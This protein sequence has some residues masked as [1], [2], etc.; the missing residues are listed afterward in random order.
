MHDLVVIPA[1][2]HAAEAAQVLLRPVRANKDVYEGLLH[3]K[4]SGLKTTYTGKGVS[5]I[6][7]QL[8][9]NS[10]LARIIV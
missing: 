1:L 9:G 7:P 6:K 5:V 8:C 2:L 10:P 4:R 3:K